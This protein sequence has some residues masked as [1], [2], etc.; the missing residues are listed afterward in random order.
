MRARWQAIKRTGNYQMYFN[1]CA[2]TVADVLRVGGADLAAEVRYRMAQVIVWTPWDLL[3]VVQLIVGHSSKI[4]RLRAQ[5]WK[6]ED[7]LGEQL[8]HMPH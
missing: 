6:R 7:E 3:E 5:G 2:A 1:N 8:M 4:E